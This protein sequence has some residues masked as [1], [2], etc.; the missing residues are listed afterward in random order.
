M[1]QEV[2]LVSAALRDLTRLSDFLADKSPR[3][4]RS[5]RATIIAAVQSLSE[6]PNRGPIASGAN[7]QL[8][9]EFG[10]DGYVAVYR[11]DPDAVVILRIFHA[12]ELR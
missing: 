1:N 4:A 6:F 3:A 9:I 7:R 12:R 11:V 10:R 5:A 2:R 8:P